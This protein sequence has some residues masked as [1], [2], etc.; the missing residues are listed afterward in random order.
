VV[1]V[2]LK[3]KLF[4]NFLDFVT[5]NGYTAI[6]YLPLDVGFGVS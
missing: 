2:S 4:A 1:A 3:K 6:D 5:F